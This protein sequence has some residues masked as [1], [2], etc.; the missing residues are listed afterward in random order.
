MVSKKSYQLQYCQCITRKCGEVEY[1]DQSGKIQR[2]NKIPQRRCRTHELEDER[3]WVATL[4]DLTREPQPAPTP[5]IELNPAA[6]PLDALIERLH[7]STTRGHRQT[8]CLTAA[9]ETISL[10]IPG[11]KHND[12]NSSNPSLL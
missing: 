7:L 3:F 2:G 12:P 1:V 5:Q 6:G 4:T 10:S 11:I 9:S 8:L